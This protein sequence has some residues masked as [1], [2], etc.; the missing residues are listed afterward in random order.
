MIDQTKVRIMTKC[1]LYENKEG[2][3]DFKI[4]Q[5]KQST[6]VG[7]KVLE[8]LICVSL[9]YFIGTGLY[10]LRYFSQILMDGIKVLKTPAIY[11]GLVYAVIMLAG[12]IGLRLFYSDQYRAA[13]RRIMKYDREL[14]HLEQYLEEQ[15]EKEETYEAE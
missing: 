11:A 9:A 6:Y 4:N 10:F 14:R 1:S 5:W 13:H 12:Y 2:K 3:K 8:S 7:M 15:Q